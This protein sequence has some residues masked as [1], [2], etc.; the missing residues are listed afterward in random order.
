[1]KL[2][3]G[4]GNPGKEYD[5]T[6][7]NIGF[8]MLDYFLKFQKNGNIEIWKPCLPAGRRGKMKEEFLEENIDGQ[9]VLFI[10]PME[11]MNRSGG[12]VSAIVHFYKIQPKDILVIHDDI[13]LPVGKI[14]LKLGGSSAGHNGLKDI[15]ARLG[16]NEFRRLRI[17][18][19]RPK[20]GLVHKGGL[21]HKLMDV[22]DYVLSSFK[23]E[24]KNIIDDKMNEIAKMIGDFL[25]S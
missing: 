23:K 10:K 9:K 11:F 19:D 25:E 16:T 2:I 24:E 14:Q 1:M 7:H 18:I 12:A 6:R 21:P 3:V 13:D 20:T 17:G 8:M 15:I 5:K 22:A 4:L